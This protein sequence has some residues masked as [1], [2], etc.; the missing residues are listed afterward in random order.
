MDSFFYILTCITFVIGVL[1]WF[2]VKPRDVAQFFARRRLVIGQYAY[3][4][5]AC[6]LSAIY[7]FALVYI[8]IVTHIFDANWLVLLGI[9]VWSLLGV[10]SSILL[11]QRSWGPRFVRIINIAGDCLATLVLIGFWFI[12]WPKWLTPLVLTALAIVALGAN[13]I[14]KYRQEI[15][16]VFQNTIHLTA[17]LKAVKKEGASKGR[18]DSGPNTSKRV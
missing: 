9:M 1:T 7:V 4:L 11:R 6:I 5:F 12:T 3:L 10:W 13:Y 17:E 8:P 16:R 14:V 2:G 15:R 18:G